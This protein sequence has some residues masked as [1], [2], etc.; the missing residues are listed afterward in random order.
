M[1]SH[2][3]RYQGMFVQPAFK[4]IDEYNKAHYSWSKET[5]LKEAKTA[6]AWGQSDKE[7]TGYSQREL[8][9]IISRLVKHIEA[10]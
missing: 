7:S 9:N 5:L 3:N 6:M 2:F 10:S 4:S 8:V 1:T